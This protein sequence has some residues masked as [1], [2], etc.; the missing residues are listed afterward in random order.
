M[1]ALMKT[2]VYLLALLVGSN[3]A[4]AQRQLKDIPKASVDSE[5]G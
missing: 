5:L 4:W 1:R 3:L 2:V